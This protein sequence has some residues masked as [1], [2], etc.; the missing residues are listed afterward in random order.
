MII[1]IEFNENELIK[2][3][4]S[5][6]KYTLSLSNTHVCLKIYFGFLIILMKIKCTFDIVNIVLIHKYG[7]FLFFRVSKKSQVIIQ[8][9]LKQ[10][11]C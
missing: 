8:F 7:N 1:R 5:R 6:Q 3:Y 10:L 11:Q 4:L 2:L 9:D